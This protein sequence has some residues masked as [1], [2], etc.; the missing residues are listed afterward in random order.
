MAKRGER[1]F[2]SCLAEH[3]LRFVHR[4]RERR[5]RGLIPTLG[6]VVKVEARFYRH[7]MRVV[8]NGEP[9]TLPEGCTVADLVVEL[10]LQNRR[11]A[12]EINREIVPRTRYAEH[13]IREADRVEIVH[14]VGGG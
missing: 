6:Q 1:Y 5:P 13:R 10:G 4:S 3:V 8:I 11:I 2:G 14:F 9:R 7:R 12:V